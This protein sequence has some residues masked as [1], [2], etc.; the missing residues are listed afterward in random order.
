LATLNGKVYM[1]SL[2]TDDIADPSSLALGFP[3]CSLALFNG[4]Y[5]GTN[6]FNAVG[7][8]VMPLEFAA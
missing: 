4:Y 1:V 5:N 2:D 3:V 7:F 6:G 8:E